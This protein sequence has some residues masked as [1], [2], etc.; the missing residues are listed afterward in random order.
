[1]TQTATPT[2]IVTGGSRGFGRAIV[3]DLTRAGWA[4]ITDGRNGA[5]LRGAFAP[6]GTVTAIAGDITDPAHRSA[7]V[8]AAQ[9]TG[10]LDLVVNNAG[11]LGPAPLPRLDALAA[12]DL[13]EVLDANVVAPA[14]LIALALPLLRTSR[15]AVI[16]ITSDAS[17]EAYEGWGA[18]GASKAALDH[19]SAILAAEEPKVSVW[20]LDPGDMRT[21]MHQAAFPGEDISDRPLPEASAPAVRALVDGRPP[22][23]RV[24]AAELLQGVPA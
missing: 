13:R 6:G 10:R 18:Y 5:A 15:G 20:A 1:M 24:R 12:D 21:D 3:T 11:A 16:N 14:A 19:L 7:L 23:G 4:V 17:V 2:A 9:H 8:D 22:S